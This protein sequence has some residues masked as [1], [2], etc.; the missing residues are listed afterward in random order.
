MKKPGVGRNE[1]CPC[2]SG[3]KYKKC[4]LGKDES[5][6]IN[7][8]SADMFADLHQALEGQEFASMEDAQS[9]VAGFV[10]QE[11]QAQV[12]DFH[13]LS[14]E[15]MANVLNAP[16]SSPQLVSFPECL[17]NEPSAPILTLFQLLV[18]AIGE[19]GLKPTAKG[20]L[21][22]KLCRASALSY[23]GEETYERN[24]RYGGINK[25]EDFFELHVTRLVAELAGLIRKY[26]GRFILSRNCRKLLAEGGMAAIYP[27]LFRAFVEQ[28]NWAYGDR[29]VAIDFIQHSFLFSLYLLNRY[30]DDSQ[31]SLFYEDCFLNAFP[32][33]VSEVE[34]QPHW[35]PEQA[36]RSVYT[37]RT[38]VRYAHFLGLARVEP[39]EI[40]KSY[41]SEYQVTKLPLLDQAVVFV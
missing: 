10:E 30:G 3:K 23:W 33:V 27:L 17:D 7:A 28:Y 4:C 34:P 20:N 14:P 5:G 37:L 1:P 16:F 24:T 29:H 21:P 8:A 36:I 2:G 26:K 12:D 13:G 35:S 11:N 40:E 41:V 19:Q 9:F 15:Q 6:P 32:M 31:S 25:E 18:D 38:L 39:V 22:Q